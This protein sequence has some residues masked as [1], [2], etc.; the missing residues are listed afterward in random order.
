MAQLYLKYQQLQVPAELH[1][2]AGVG[3]GFGLRSTNEAAVADWP[4]QVR[5]WLREIGILKK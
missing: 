4:R 3:H 2:Y 5:L 1:I